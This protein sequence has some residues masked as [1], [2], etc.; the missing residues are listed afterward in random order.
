[1]SKPIFSDGIGYEGKVTLTLKSNNRILKST[2]YKN[3][4]TALLFKF[5]GDCLI[6]SYED[7]KKYLPSKLMLLYNNSGIMVDAVNATSVNACSTWQT[8]AKMPA[9][10]SEANPAQVKVIY[11]FEIPRAAI[12]KAFNQ[13]ALYGADVNNI[14][15]F[16]AYYYL[17][18]VQG[19]LVPEDASSWSATTILLIEWELSLSNKNVQGEQ[20]K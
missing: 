7:A 12:S 10:I 18:N 5:L 6:G 19:E 2:T 4:G 9:I 3:N 8:L 13:V 11:S 1:M 17:T 20:K 14:D 16:S 15:E